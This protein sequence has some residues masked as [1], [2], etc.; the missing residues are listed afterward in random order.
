[1]SPPDL[2]SRPAAS[3]GT[4]TTC[5]V[6]GKVT[7]NLM[8]PRP[9]SMAEAGQVEAL[10]TGTLV[11]LRVAGSPDPAVVDRLRTFGAHLNYEVHGRDGAST[12]AWV[13]ALRNGRYLA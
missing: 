11:I 8:Q 12:G 5:N 7:L 3:R 13:R 9:A 4:G 10:P 1:V 2:R 6:S